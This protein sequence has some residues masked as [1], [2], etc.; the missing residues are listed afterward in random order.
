MELD[1]FK[2]EWSQYDKKLSANLKLNEE[3]LYKLNLNNSK[4]EMQKPLVYE[5]ISIAILFLFIVYILANALRLVDQIQYSIPGFVSAGIMG[6]YLVFAIIRA[7][8]F[9]EIDYYNT[10]VLKLQRDVLSLK[11]KVL[12][13]RKYE[14]IL[15]PFLVLPLIPLLF[16]VIHNINIYQ[17]IRLL[18]IEVVLI[19]AIG[20]PLVIWINKYLYDHKF[21]NSEKLL[22]EL[23]EFEKEG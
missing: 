5:L 1:D 18:V 23:D 19:L 6:I 14:L 15:I 22:A 2:K 12:C 3:L 17:N 11:K 7:K 10:P 16:K 4:R 9:L 13:Y 20:Y 8:G 21:R